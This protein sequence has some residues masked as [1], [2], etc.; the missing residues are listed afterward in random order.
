MARV[1]MDEARAGFAA[2]VNRAP[3]EGYGK[4]GKL[5]ALRLLLHEASQRLQRLATE[6]RRRMD[7]AKA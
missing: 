3:G 2:Q 4:P 7:Q 5:P 6:M 1:P